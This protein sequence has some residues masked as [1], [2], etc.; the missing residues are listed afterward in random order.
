MM[1]LCSGMTCACSDITVASQL[2]SLLINCARHMPTI[3]ITEI[4]A[5]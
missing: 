3:A 4:K 1:P 5:I 2:D